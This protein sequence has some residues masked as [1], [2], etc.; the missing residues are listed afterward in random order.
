MMLPK[1]FESQVVG[2]KFTVTPYVP[3][4]SDN[5]VRYSIRIRTWSPRGSI[6]YVANRDDLVKLRDWINSA[7]IA[8]HGRTRGENSDR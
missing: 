1:L 4:H 5:V 2:H 8:E 6:E 7:L 3:Q